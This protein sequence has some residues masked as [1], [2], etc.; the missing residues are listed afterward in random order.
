MFTE[1]KAERKIFSRIEL[2]VFLLMVISIA[3]GAYTRFKGLGNWPLATDEFYT[4][5]SV[6]NILT[7][8]LPKFETGGYYLRGI[9]FQYIESLFSLVGGFDEGTLRVLPVVC[10]LL[11]LPAIYL[12]GRVL[13]NR[14]IGFVAVTLISLSVWEIEFS[15]FIR[16]YTVF[17]TIFLWFIYF[18]YDVIINRNTS[19]YKWLYVLTILALFVHE[20]VVFMSLLLFFPNILGFKE[21]HDKLNILVGGF[22]FIACL[23]LYFVGGYY[24]VRFVEFIGEHFDY[25]ERFYLPNFYLLKTVYESPS[26]LFLYVCVWVIN[27]GFLFQ[28]WRVKDVAL[29]KKFLYLVLVALSLFQM[30]GLLVFIFILAF[31]ANKIDPKDIYTKPIGKLAFC[32][33]GNLIFWISFGLANDSW[34]KYFD[35]LQSIHARKIFVVLFKFPNIFDSFIYPW[36][37]AMPILSMAIFLTA[38]FLLIYSLLGR[39]EEKKIVNFFIFVCI[40]CIF[41]I[42]LI[43]STYVSTRYSF[44][45]YPLFLLLWIFCLY[46]LSKRVFYRSKMALY[47]VFSFL[48]ILFFIVLEDFNLYHILN[49]DKLQMNFRTIYSPSVEVHYYRRVDYKTPAEFINKNLLP[50]EKVF[51]TIVPVAF[52]LKKIDVIYMNKNHPDF[53]GVLTKDGVR[54]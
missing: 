35:G 50:G 7:E 37:K 13:G 18:L 14:L 40:F 3:F 32:S 4:A 15:R 53:M 29:E 16:M 42:G 48:G 38:G 52:Y 17:Q 26:W 22:I 12:L 23:Y 20:A 46:V 30:F 41:I 44:F 34:I 51:S 49:I 45:L 11:S 1:N 10:N 54:E 33:L 8:G 9:L 25:Y 19:S 36:L 27:A 5:M 39:L 2:S 6:K 31:L 28:L 24:G 43:K 47:T 21:K